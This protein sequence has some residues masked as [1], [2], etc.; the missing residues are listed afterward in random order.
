MTVSVARRAAVSAPSVDPAA[1]QDWARAHVVVL[2][3]VA[4]AVVVA[5]MLV[6]GRVEGGARSVFNV[7]LGLGVIAGALLLY[8]H[9]D[10]LMGLF[11]QSR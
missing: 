11:S 6:A 4:V 9:A 1:V 3:V 2:V 8:G 5:V 10:Q 7:V